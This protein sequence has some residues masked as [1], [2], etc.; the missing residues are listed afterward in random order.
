MT[1]K[2]LREALRNCLPDSLPET[3]QRAVLSRI[4]ERKQPMKRKVSLA[5]VLA[6]VLLALGAVA[7]AVVSRYSVADYSGA[8]QMT[9]EMQNSIVDIDETY[10]NAY[11]TMTANDV[12]YDGE[13]VTMAFNFTTKDPDMHLYLYPRLTAEVDGQTY[14]ADVESFGAG[15]FMSG[16]VYPFLPGHDLAAQGY[17]FGLDAVL[18]DDDCNLIRPA[19]EVRWTLTMKVFK[20]NFEVEYADVVFDGTESEEEMQQKMDVFAQAFREHK[21]LVTN[22][23]SLAEWDSQI[24][25]PDGMT[26]E[27]WYTMEPFES[28]TISGAYDLMDVVKISFTTQ[29]PENAVS[30]TGLNL[31]VPTEKGPLTLHIDLLPQCSA[32]EIEEL[33]RRRLSSMPEL[34]T[35]NLLAG[36]LHN[37][38]GRTVLRYAGYGLTDPVASLSPADLRKIAGAAKDFA[39][40]V[41]SVLGFDGAQVTA[42]GIRTAEFDP[43]TLQSRLLPGLYAAGEVLDIDGDCGGYN[44]QWAWSSGYLAGLLKSGT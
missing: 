38:L 34:T 32:P 42:G 6:L 44:L 1:E 4:Q 2:Q 10:E 21:I 36:V 37:R 12:L 28:L 43:K 17:G 35:E 31:T 8:G 19:G 23:T 16:F 27:E 9:E 11:M 5:L 22:D 29:V 24:P 7:Y 39:L 41:V 40:P 30:Q 15:D 14:V 25:I 33:L 18:L 20:P 3:Q 13:T 26:E